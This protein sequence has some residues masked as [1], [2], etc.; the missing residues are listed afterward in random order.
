MRTRPP[1][2]PEC[3]RPACSNS[4]QICNALTRILVPRTRAA[5]F[6]D[7]LAAEVSSLVVGDPTDSDTQVGPLVA[8]RQQQRVAGYLEQG[9]RDGARVVTGGSGMPDGCDRGWYVKPTLF[10]RG[11]QLDDASPARRSSARC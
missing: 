5:E 2:R 7:A 11:G 8:Q 1:S 3:G 9:I 10:D 4:G 6:T